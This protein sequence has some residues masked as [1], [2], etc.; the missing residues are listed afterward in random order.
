MVPPWLLGAA[1]GQPGPFGM[2]LTL[3]RVQLGGVELL[4]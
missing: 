1:Q 4:P 3:P 2:V